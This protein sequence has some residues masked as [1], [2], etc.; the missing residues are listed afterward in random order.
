MP[1]SL[2]RLRND[3]KCVEWDVKPYY[4]HTLQGQENWSGSILQLVGS[5]AHVVQKSVTEM[6]FIPVRDRRSRQDSRQ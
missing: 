1:Q 4:T 2:H 3:L 5:W 6:T